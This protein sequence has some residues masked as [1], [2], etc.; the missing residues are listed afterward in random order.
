MEGAAPHFRLRG[1]SPSALQQG[2]AAACLGCGAAM[3]HCRC[4][5]PCCR[6]CTSLQA[7]WTLLGAA[8]PSAPRPTPHQ[9]HRLALRCDIL[10][11]LLPTP[12]KR[13][14]AGQGPAQVRARGALP[15]QGSAELFRGYVR[16][17]A[18]GC[19]AGLNEHR[20]P[21]A[22]AAACHRRRSLPPFTAAR[23]VPA[24]IDCR[25]SLSYICRTVQE[26]PWHS[27]SCTTWP[28]ALPVRAG[29]ACWAAHLP[30]CAPLRYFAS[31]GPPVVAESTLAFVIKSLKIDSATKGRCVR[32]LTAPAALAAGM[33]SMQACACAMQA[34]GQ[35]PPLKNPNVLQPSITSYTAPTHAAR[36]TISV[37]TLRACSQAWVRAGGW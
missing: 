29:I 8:R 20:P 7:A 19:T 31:A 34:R 37:A 6:C 25:W 2:G 13:T 22:A 17:L 11:R 14:G 4:C 9:R 24:S 15:M 33:C 26:A 5:Q 16:P 12:G 27:L 18:L 3:Q 32:P 30:C 36:V 28:P 35:P 10:P 23:G 1:C 21:R